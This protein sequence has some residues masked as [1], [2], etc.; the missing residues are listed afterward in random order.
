MPEVNFL[1]NKIAKLN[2]ILGNQHIQFQVVE[3]GNALD[4][5]EASGEGTS[6]AAAGGGNCSAAT[7]GDGNGKRKKKKHQSDQV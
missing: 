2:S 4:L 6:S 5:G 1:R 3:N 7:V